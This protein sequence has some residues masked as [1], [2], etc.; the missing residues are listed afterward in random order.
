[1]RAAR[2]R[3]RRTETAAAPLARKRPDDAA[4]SS[5]GF[6][7]C[8]DAVLHLER[9]EPMQR[10]P[11]IYASSLSRRELARRRARMRSSVVARAGNLV[12]AVVVITLAV[13]ISQ[14]LVT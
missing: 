2:R 4:T 8:A 1:M 13:L 9:R 10:L 3:R 14:R 12:G 6:A 5:C 11:G 7:R